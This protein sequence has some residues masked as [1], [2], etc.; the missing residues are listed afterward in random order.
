MTINDIVDVKC[1]SKNFKFSELYVSIDL[2]NQILLFSKLNSYVD[3]SISEMNKILCNKQN[4]G[5]KNIS[6]TI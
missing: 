1:V 5:Y 2:I 4:E 3:W 6:E